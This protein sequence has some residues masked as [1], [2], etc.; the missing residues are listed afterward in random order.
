[1]MDEKLCTACGKKLKID[2][3]ICT[4]CGVTQIND[5]LNSKGYKPKRA[6]T[7]IWLLLLLGLLGVHRFYVGKIIT[8]IIMLVLTTL[9]FLSG[10]SYTNNPII[11]KLLL[12]F[13]VVGVWWV[14]DFIRI[15]MGFFSDKKG[16]KLS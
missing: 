8:G 15:V 2:S 4:N 13:I 6:V 3:K 11:Q 1:M 5:E 10:I 12:S 9:G 14:I 16:N 7:T